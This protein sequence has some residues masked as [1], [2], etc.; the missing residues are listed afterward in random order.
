MVSICTLLIVAAIKGWDLQQLDVNNV[1]LNGELD[2]ELYTWFP[3]GLVSPK[4]NQ[5]CK[6]HKSIY[7]LPR[8]SC[9]W[10]TKLSS[11]LVEFGF[12]QSK[13]NYSLFIKHTA[14]SF[15]AQLVNVNDII[16]MSLDHMSTDEVKQFLSTKFKIKNLSPLKYFLGMEF[17]QSKIGIQIANASTPWIFYPR[18]A[19][20]LPNPHP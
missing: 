18:L 1:F 11:S 16:L 19:Y 15:T 6:L 7:C 10:N 12:V 8:A 14:S 3:P 4:A 13:S 9:Q 5:V 20:L 2:E 17:A